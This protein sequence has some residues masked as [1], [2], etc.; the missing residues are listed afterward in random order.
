M[1]LSIANHLVI[2]ATNASLIPPL[3]TRPTYLPLPTLAIRAK[4]KLF[5]KILGIQNILGKQAQ[6]MPMFLFSSFLSMLPGHFIRGNF[7]GYGL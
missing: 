7:L 3:L 4:S 5:G 6:K 1:F 2:Q